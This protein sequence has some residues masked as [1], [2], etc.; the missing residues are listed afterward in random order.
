MST[1]SNYYVENF[2]PWALIAGAS[3]GLGAAYAEE[4]ARKGLNVILLART[5]EKLEQLAK[6]IRDE[7]SVKAQIIVQDLSAE[8]LLE[9]IKNKTDKL[10]VGFL[11]CNAALSPIGLFLN[12]SLEQH[13]KVI[14][15]NC[16]APMVLTHHFGKLMKERKRG[17]ILLMTSLAGLQGNP[18]HAHYSSTRA[19]NINLAEALWD[20][21]KQD[22]IQVMACLAGATNTPN[23]RR[24][25]P[26]KLGFFAPKVLKPETVAKQAVKAIKKTR[27]PLFIPGFMNRVYSC[28]MQNLIPRKQTVKMMGNIA[29]DMYGEEKN[30]SNK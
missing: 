21:L 27:K 3:E 13:E 17:A 10:E 7:Y 1:I 22:N 26:K 16:R 8:N 25:K 2:G 5:E 28:I 29:R 19:Y 14:A 15:V 23:Y 6:K 12:T 18:V 30:H 9:E 4:L 24:S 20:E 11:V